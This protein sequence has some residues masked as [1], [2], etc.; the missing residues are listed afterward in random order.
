MV[1]YIYPQGLEGEQNRGE[2]L[3]FS[4]AMEGVVYEVL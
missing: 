2:E 4:V 3:S 1:L